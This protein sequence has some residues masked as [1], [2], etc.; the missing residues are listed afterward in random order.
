MHCIDSYGSYSLQTGGQVVDAHLLLREKY[1]GI[2]LESLPQLILNI[3]N[4]VLM[5]QTSLI[6]ILSFAFSGFMILDGIYRIMWIRFVA[7]RTY[8]VQK[9]PLEDYEEPKQ[10][11]LLQESKK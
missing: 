3:V 11:P 10:P 9:I 7:N 5:Q 6:S 4:A 2:L 8:D 1:L